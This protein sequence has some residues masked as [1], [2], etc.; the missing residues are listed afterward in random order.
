VTDAKKPRTDAELA[1]AAWFVTMGEETLQVVGRDDVSVVREIAEIE[2]IIADARAAERA[3]WARVLREWAV[4]AHI[5]HHYQYAEA[6]D[7]AADAICSDDDK[8]RET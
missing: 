6:L 3:R 8:P 1:E 2:A 7:D 4:T 5:N